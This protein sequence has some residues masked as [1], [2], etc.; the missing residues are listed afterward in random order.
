VN[1]AFGYD[2]VFKSVIKSVDLNWLFEENIDHRGKS[3]DVKV[4]IAA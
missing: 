2:N 1:C 4:A 3:V